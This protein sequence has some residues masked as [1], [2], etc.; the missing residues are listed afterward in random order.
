MEEA[1][2]EKAETVAMMASR[3]TRNERM[4]VGRGSDTIIVPA[5]EGQ[6]RERRRLRGIMAEEIIN[7]SE[8]GE[9][10]DYESDDE[11]DVK[12]CS[13][14]LK[15]F[16]LNCHKGTV[17]SESDIEQFQ[18]YS[19]YSDFNLFGGK[20]PDWLERNTPRMDIL[21]ARLE[22]YTRWFND[23]DDKSP[24][25][26]IVFVS[27][28]GDEQVIDPVVWHEPSIDMYWQNFFT[29]LRQKITTNQQFV[30]I[31]FLDINGVEMT[32]ETVDLM[33]EVFGQM[34]INSIQT[35]AVKD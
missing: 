21:K 32:K 17:I 1:G 19:T 25:Q 11:S 6:K 23:E 4:M 24:V 9:S 18:G 28:I 7:E 5:Q 3:R 30:K 34:S 27:S 22:E 20:P 35:C 26:N 33:A 16:V 10:D 12:V 14:E 15:H 13:D 29:A 8:D 31:T 2:G